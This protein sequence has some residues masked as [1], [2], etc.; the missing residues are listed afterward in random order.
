MSDDITAR[1][2]SG[3]SEF[4]AAFGRG[5]A[6]GIAG[7]Y[8]A[9]AQLLPANSDVVQGTAAIRAFWQGALDMGLKAARLETLEVDAQGDTAIEIG[10]YTLRVAGDAVADAGKYLVVWKNDA[11]RWKIH[12]DIWTTSQPASAPV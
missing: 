7:L 4:M 12:R 6:A 10:R 5:D 9:D 3:N 8:T 2:E 11:G 1:I